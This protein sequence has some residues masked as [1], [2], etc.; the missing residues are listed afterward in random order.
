MAD[1]YTRLFTLPS[2]LYT[3]GSPLVI[4]AGALLKDTQT[5]RV[6]AQLKLRSISDQRIRAVKLRVIG[7]D[8][9]QAVLCEEEHQY[10]DLDVKRDTLFGAKEAILLPSS[11]VRS[12]TAELLAVYFTDG[13]S[14]LYEDSRWESLPA[15][16]DL[17]VRL[18]DAEL[19]R[20]YR[21]ETSEKSRYVPL[22]TRD[23]WLC[24]C[25][26][27][28]HP[29]ECCHRCGV[30]LDSL[31]RLLDVDVLRESKNQRLLDEAAEAARRDEQRHSLAYR[32]KRAGLVLIPVLLIGALMLAVYIVSSKRDARYRSADE[33]FSA[34]SYSE[35][36]EL[37]EALGSYR[38]AASKAE[39]ARE[40]A[41]RVSSYSRAG[42]LLENGR[43][44]DAYDAYLSLG[45]YQD[46]ARLALE[47][48]Y[49]KALELIEKGPEAY[50]EAIALLTE[51]GDYAEA[52]SV[53]SRFHERLLTKDLNY[54]AE[55][56]GPLSISYAYDSAG[57]I[58]A[59][60]EL[61][62]AYPGK[63]D[64]VSTYAYNEDGSYSILEGQVEKRYDAYGGF[65]GQGEVSTYFYDY[66]FFDSGVMHYCDTYDVETGGYRG[67][68]V[69]DEHGNRVRVTASDGTLTTMKNEYE[70][71][72]LVR[73]ESFSSDGAM[74]DRLS[75][76]Y[77]AEGRLKRTT[78]MVVDGP[79]TVT[80]YGYGLIY[81]PDA[82][83]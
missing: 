27:I 45:N 55:A 65:L 75:C 69:N 8:V 60:T 66:G 73:Q 1:R 16:E 67:E 22:E 23:L 3:A 33:L 46:A 10:L 30:D 42:K 61:F 18:F 13:T 50:D 9:S 12:F 59:V 26:E 25:G 4:A 35:A 56:D 20:Q 82:E 53:L 48:R 51:L 72:H 77:D 70:D 28:N 43:Y 37:Y 79:T 38:D 29:F 68:F 47:A 32:L 71:D 63:K 81:A 76:E 80:S 64:R 24:S 78:Y 2:D 57:R 40:A 62:S 41:A 21:L 15:Q 34:G 11:A 7:Y 54:D 19:I 44:D 14:Y 83:S 31:N 36:A 17:T 74:L 58:S 39:A 49:R 6:L 5:G 52:P